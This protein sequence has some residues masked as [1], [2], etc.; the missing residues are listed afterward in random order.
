MFRLSNGESRKIDTGDGV[1]G[2]VLEQWTLSCLSA[3][4]SRESSI[5]DVRGGGGGTT[6]GTNTATHRREHERERERPTYI[7]PSSSSAYKSGIIH[8]RA[9]YQ[10]IRLLPAYA[11]YRRLKRKTN[12]LKIGIKMWCAEGWDGDYRVPKGGISDAS[13]AEGEGDGLRDAWE[14]MENG[15]IGLEDRSGGDGGIKDFSFPGVILGNGVFTLNCRS[16]KITD[17][18]I[19]DP[20]AALSTGFARE[21]ANA[22][23]TREGF[24]LNEEYFTPTLAR[25][26][27]SSSGDRPSSLPDEGLNR[28][29]AGLSATRPTELQAQRRRS[30]EVEAAAAATAMT[31]GE[32][33][34]GDV[35]GST[36]SLR[37]WSNLGEGLPFAI[38]QGQSRPDID[39]LRTSSLSG[40]V[41]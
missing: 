24:D 9:L 10:Y 13:T 37:R 38:P 25:R 22:A 26:R 34:N 1:K 32:K 14:K 35:I 15:L 16:R 31:T 3:L 40:R 36:G 4:G 29:M 27:T 20:E 11:L 2:I 41:S 18:W 5:D 12:G 39:R 23:A 30:I 17:Y 21:D 8:F 6:G 28:R 19:E 7:P 33:S